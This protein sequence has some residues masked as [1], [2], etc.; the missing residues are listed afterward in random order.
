MDFAR[1]S[2]YALQLLVQGR[3]FDRITEHFR[4]GN[5]V[6][7]VPAS[8]CVYAYINDY[9]YSKK[10]KEY[11]LHQMKLLPTSRSPYVTFQQRKVSSD[12]YLVGSYC[13]FLQASRA[14]N[15][16]QKLFVDYGKTF[17]ATSVEFYYLQ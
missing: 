11:E 16:S 10:N 4:K 15:L 9:C 14:K 2:K 12:D 3:G 17:F 5:A 6:R 13:V 7:C 1:I 8:L